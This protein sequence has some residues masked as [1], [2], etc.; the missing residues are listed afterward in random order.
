MA[1]TTV[2]ITGHILGPSGVAPTSG[3]VNIR[4]SV[5][6][7]TLDGAES[8]RVAGE[9]SVTLGAGGSFSAALVP[10]DLI[11]PSGTYYLAEVVLRLPNGRSWSKAE[12]WQLTSADL[13]LDI[14]AVPQIDE[15]SHSAYVL[16]EAVQASVLASA[17]ASASAASSSAS[18]AAGSEGAAAV[19]AASVA[20]DASATSSA[21]TSA[22]S[23]RD[24]ALAVAH[25]AAD[26][27]AGITATTS[28]DYFFVPVAGSVDSFI[29][30]KNVDD[31]A[32]NVL[33][34]CRFVSSV[35]I[36][37]LFPDNAPSGTGWNVFDGQGRVS[38]G[39]RDDGTV[40]AHT[41]EGEYVGT[42]TGAMTD[43]ADNPGTLAAVKDDAG[44]FAWAVRDDGTV[45]I[46]T[47]AVAALTEVETVNGIRS[48]RLL[49]AVDPPNLNGDLVFMNLH[50][51]SLAVG[52][53]GT[54][55]SNVQQYDT[56]GFVSGA[57]APV[58]YLAATN[59]NLQNGY[60]PPHFGAAEMVKKLLVDEDRVLY[61]DQA[62][63]LVICVNALGSTSVAQHQKGSTCFTNGIA[64][65]TALVAI[66]QAEGRTCRA[67]AMLWVQGEQDGVLGTG[68][69]TYKASLLQL[70]NDW[71][72]D[73]K[74]LTNQTERAPIISYQV[75]SYPL[76]GVAQLNAANENPGK[77]YIACPM[78]WPSQYLDA[79]HIPAS[80]SKTLGAY[81]GLVYK[82]VVIDGE[83]WEPLQPSAH[84]RQ[85]KILD[86]VF[87][88]RDLVLDTTLV[89][90][91]PTSGF[92]LFDN[93]GAAITI[94]SVTVIKPD[95]V[96]IAAAATIPAGSTLKY[97]VN[98][99]TGKSPY[100]G[101]AGNLRDSQGDTIRA[102][103]L[104]LSQPLHN[105]CCLFSRAL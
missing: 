2:A 55:L 49:A 33:E 17:T 95:T 1:V 15:A 41:I 57:A 72:T 61:T 38:I 87:N 99:A 16:H 74:A 65:L 22:E 30:Y 48:D 63:K 76:I 71:D 9:H 66:A 42:A 85:G 40:E 83:A 46:G 43:E 103:L 92:T 53:G 13:T 80:Q 19:S 4:L 23:A 104:N 58:A 29:V 70:A 78:Y 51:Q 32:P 24:A 21:R 45:E 79:L 96:R 36:S 94:N 14:G 47:G 11:T 50:G 59:D 3:K 7:S 82:R 86:V 28:G 69:A 97:G 73:A 26:I 37:V 6:G 62:H 8:V 77:I 101:G 10:N 20:A 31:T 35:R 84:L 105:W 88:K 34:V 91:Q 64:Q 39:T 102:S 67:G 68:E 54:E 81:L 52:P 27:A 90:A 44:A 5:H 18:A 25:I 12:K 93:V 98:T 56:V 75:G 89:P 60:E 100:V